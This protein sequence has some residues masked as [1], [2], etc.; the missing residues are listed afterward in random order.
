MASRGTAVAV[1]CVI[2]LLGIAIATVAYRFRKGLEY[3]HFT[4]DDLSYGVKASLEQ[5]VLQG[6]PEGPAAHVDRVISIYKD[7]ILGKF[8]RGRYP[9]LVARVHMV[10]KLHAAY[11]AT[12]DKQDRP[13]FDFFGIDQDG[14]PRLKETEKYILDNKAAIRR[15]LRKVLDRIGDVDDVKRARDEYN[16]L[17]RRRE[18]ENKGISCAELDGLLEKHKL[19]AKLEVYSHRNWSKT[20]CPLPKQVLP[21]SH[22]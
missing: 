16:D 20:P 18:K 13:L 9:N 8:F 10:D 22:G 2:L 1:S 12:E 15:K 5:A 19:A 6:A 11:T 21:I 4:I 7:T 17:Y 3:K 14:G